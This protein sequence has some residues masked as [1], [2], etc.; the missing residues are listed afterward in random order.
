MGCKEKLLDLVGK[1]AG[2]ETLADPHGPLKYLYHIDRHIIINKTYIRFLGLGSAAPLSILDIGAG[3]G[4]FVCL[5]RELGHR[6]LTI[7]TPEIDLYGEAIAA[8]KIPRVEHRITAFSRIPEHVGQ[9]DLITSIAIVFNGHKS[10]RAWKQEEWSFFI[11]DLL[12]HC[13]KDGRIFLVLNRGDYSLAEME[14]LFLFKYDAVIT[15]G[16]EVL[17]NK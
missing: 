4:L 11:D 12:S 6:I 8:L 10:E 17:I 1:Y 5:C 15:N 16:N 14:R 3:I 2:A 13:N 9:F 7:D